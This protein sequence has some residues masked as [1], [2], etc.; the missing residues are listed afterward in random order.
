MP[1][2]VVANVLF[3][4]QLLYYIFYLY[5]LFIMN[6]IIVNIYRRYPVNIIFNELVQ[7]KK[8]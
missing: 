3:M 4:Y 8:K 2:R 1:D 6:A 5:I 7:E